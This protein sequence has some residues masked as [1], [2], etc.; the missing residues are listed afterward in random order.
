MR[1]H[2]LLQALNEV[3]KEYPVYDFNNFELKID[4]KDVAQLSLDIEHFSIKLATE[5]SKPQEVVEAQSPI[6]VY[7]EE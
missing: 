6:K 2:Q 1:I 7:D 3:K 5:V 4:E